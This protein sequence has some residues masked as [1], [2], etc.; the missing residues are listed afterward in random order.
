M[1]A[2]NG[3]AISR[4]YAGTAAMKVCC[5]FLMDLCTF[6][7][8]VGQRKKSQSPERIQTLASSY[9]RSDFYQLSYRTVFVFFFVVVVV[10]VVVVVCLGAGG[11][12]P[13]DHPLIRRLFVPRSN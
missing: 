13:Y 5:T 4:Q 6:V 12:P 11:T 7:T 10:V 2:S 9:C 3:D 1:W 8:S